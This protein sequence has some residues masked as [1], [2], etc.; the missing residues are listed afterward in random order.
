MPVA[1][2]RPCG[3][4]VTVGVRYR[5]VNAMLRAVGARDRNVTDEEQR[6]SSQCGAP[7]K[8]ACSYRHVEM[9]RRQFFMA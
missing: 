5:H 9:A 1:D 6:K 8:A 3:R 7:W 4:N 2:S